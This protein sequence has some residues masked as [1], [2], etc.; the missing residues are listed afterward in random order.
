MFLY[1][2]FAHVVCPP[3]LKF[4][5]R[6]VY[7]KIGEIDT[8]KENFAADIFLQMKWREPALD[9]VQMVSDCVYL[10]G[11]NII[12]V[13]ILNILNVPLIVYQNNI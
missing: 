5:V 2:I 10:I 13:N 1:I 9:H 8:V 4:F 7:L 11:N 3:R 12:V 6:I